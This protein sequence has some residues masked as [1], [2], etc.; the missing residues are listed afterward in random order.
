MPNHTYQLFG[1]PEY[2][3][4]KPNHAVTIPQGLFATDTN[5]TLAQL[6]EY[7]QALHGASFTFPV[8]SGTDIPAKIKIEARNILFPAGGQSPLSPGNPIVDVAVNR[9]RPSGEPTVWRDSTLLYAI[10][11]LSNAYL[12]GG[13]N[14]VTVAPGP[15]SPPA[16]W[17]S[18]NVVASKV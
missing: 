15:G 9:S 18:A 6:T 10:H 4:L 5:I 12:Q 16:Y 11:P 1:T 3:V 14:L 17:V 2:T 7:I 8:S 13:P